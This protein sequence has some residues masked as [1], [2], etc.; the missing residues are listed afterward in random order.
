MV[1][2]TAAKVTDDDCVIFEF[3]MAGLHGGDGAGKRALAR[4]DDEEIEEKR[5]EGM[6][7]GKKKGRGQQLGV[8][9]MPIRFSP[10]ITSSTP[11]LPI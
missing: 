9:S 5:K 1:K 3:L 8:L 2:M 6:G 10:P 4:H 11:L 7:E